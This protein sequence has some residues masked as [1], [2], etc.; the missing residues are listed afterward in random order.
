MNRFL[1]ASCHDFPPHSRGGGELCAFE[2]LSDFK[3]LTGV[4]VSVISS[5]LLVDTETKYN[6]GN[7]RIYRIPSNRFEQTIKIALSKSPPTAVLTYLEETGMIIRLCE[8]CKIPVVLLVVDRGGVFDGLCYFTRKP[9]CVV[10]I[11]QYLSKMAKDHFGIDALVYPPRIPT[12]KNKSIAIPKRYALATVGM[13]NPNRIKGGKLFNKLAI[14]FPEV[15]FLAVRGW[16]YPSIAPQVELSNPNI[17]ILEWQE[18]V[19]IFYDRISVLIV[20]SLCP[21]GY[22]R[23]VREAML[24]GIPVIA[25]DRGALVES[26]CGGGI[27]LN[28]FDE[29][30][31]GK[32]IQKLLENQEEYTSIA[33]KGRLAVLEAQYR[34]AETALHS[35][36]HLAA[37]L[38][39]LNS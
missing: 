16:S 9:D 18:N 25:S 23:V 39:L 34:D 36:R 33:D 2:L 28:P 38:G 10:T 11:S 22:G 31:W 19:D 24:R 8:E 13:I 26:S 14:A 17:E 29:Q 32:Q 35:V 27:Y 5:G 37:T 12:P 3:T 7:F 6:Y 1:L 21:E 15:K 4:D 30:A 20:P